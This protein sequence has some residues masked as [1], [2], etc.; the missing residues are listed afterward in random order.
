MKVAL[1][2]VSA[3][4]LL[5]EPGTATAQVGGGIVYEIGQGVSAPVVVKEVKPQYS[6]EAMKAKIQGVVVVEC[7]V[8]PDGVPSAVRVV[9]SLDPALDLEATKAVRQWRFK[10]GMKDG[11]PVPVL[12]TIELTFAPR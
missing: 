9:R 11:K 10:P 4:C 1:G 5:A 12:V 3:L 6:A 2:I 7:V 8:M